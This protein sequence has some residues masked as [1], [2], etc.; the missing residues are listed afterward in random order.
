MLFYGITAVLW[1]GWMV[2]G[3]Y[4]PEWISLKGK[5]V[6]FVRILFWLIGTGVH[7]YCLGYVYDF[8]LRREQLAPVAI[9]GP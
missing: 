4:M 9:R 3:W 5:D 6:W 8:K 1:I 7:L 2:L